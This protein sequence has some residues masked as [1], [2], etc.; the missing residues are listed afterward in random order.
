MELYS[1]AKEGSDRGYFM[2][3]YVPGQVRIVDFYVDSEDREAWRTA[4]ELAVAQSGR[5]PT[6]AEVVSVGSDVFTRQALLDCGFHPRGSWVLRLR[7]GKG[8]ELPTIRFHLI[9][10]D[11]AYLR[12]KGYTYWA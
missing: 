11:F 5:N 4:I 10:N 9:D 7:P 6:A 1:I 12:G 3:A 8:V 2:L